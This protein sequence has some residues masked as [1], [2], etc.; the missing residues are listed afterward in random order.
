MPAA[1]FSHR[2]PSPAE[3]QELFE[4]QFIPEPMSGCWLWIGPLFKRGGYACFTCRPAGLQM[5]RANRLSWKI[6]CG[7]VADDEHILHRC[8]NRIC[9]NPDHLFKGDQIINMRDKVSKDR[10]DRGEIHGMAKLSEDE[11][12]SIIADRRLQRLI[13]ADH[14]VSVPTVSDIKRGRSWAHLPRA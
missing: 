3:L 4:K 10:Q 12:I 6:Y 2:Q 8:D 9:V 11:A 1:G 13:A 14:G 5:V 7:P